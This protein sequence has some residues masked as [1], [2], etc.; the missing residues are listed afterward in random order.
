MGLNPLLHCWGFTRRRPQRAAMAC[1]GIRPAE[2]AFMDTTTPRAER[3]WES[4]ANRPAAEAMAWWGPA[5]TTE[6]TVTSP[7]R[8][9]RGAIQYSSTPV[10]GATPA[11]AAGATTMVGQGP[12]T[13]KFRGCS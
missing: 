10:Y 7:G 13:I 4:P 8:A 2:L 6:F 1:P 3:R 9:L 11:G 5:R 12:L